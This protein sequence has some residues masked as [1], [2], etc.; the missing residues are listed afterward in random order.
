[1]DYLWKKV[2]N[3]NEDKI[4]RIYAISYLASF[5]VRASYVSVRYVLWVGLPSL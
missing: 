2:K 3:P 1:M 4:Y 5:V